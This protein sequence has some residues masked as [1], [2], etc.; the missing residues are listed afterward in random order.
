[1]TSFTTVNFYDENMTELTIPLDPV[2]TPAQN[3]QYYF[4]KYNKAKGRKMPSKS[5]LNG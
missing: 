2:L 3:A 4:N 1:M 5:S